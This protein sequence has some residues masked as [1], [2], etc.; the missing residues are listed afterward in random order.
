MTNTWNFLLHFFPY[1]HHR[2]RSVSKGTPPIG[3][4]HSFDSRY[5]GGM[6]SVGMQ[7]SIFDLDDTEPQIGRLGHTVTRRELTD[8]AWVDLRPGW[9]T[10]CP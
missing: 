4:E 10:D 3:L 1:G 2:P 5:P 8:G 9:I 6:T 7:G